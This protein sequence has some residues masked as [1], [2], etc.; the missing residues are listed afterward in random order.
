MLQTA[1]KVMVASISALPSRIRGTLAA[2]A[3]TGRRCGDAETDHLCSR[4]GVETHEEVHSSSHSEVAR[5]ADSRTRGGANSPQVSAI[6]RSV[7]RGAARV[8]SVLKRSSKL[9]VKLC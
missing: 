8:D 3:S 2:G 7:Q 5:S 9:L 4:E 1:S 6:R